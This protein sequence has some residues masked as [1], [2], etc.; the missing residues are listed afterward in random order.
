AGI[1]VITTVNVQHIDSLNDKIAQLTGVR[2]RETI[3]DGVFAEADDVVIID[4]TPEA[5]QDRLRRGEIYPATQVER[6]LQ[7]F[8]RTTN[9]CALREL[10]LLQVADEADKDLEEH[11]RQ[12]L[13]TKIWGVQERV[14]ACIS[15]SRPSTLLIRRATRFA[16]RVHGKC[17][18]LFVAPFGG[19]GAL[20]P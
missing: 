2:V 7:N 17:Y 14:L 20:P 16:R 1:D 13:A 11:R 3:P 19:V 9:L 4:V 12:P 10:A 8:F 6:A 5:L 15:A 18:I